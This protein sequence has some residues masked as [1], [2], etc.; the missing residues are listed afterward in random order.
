MSSKTKKEQRRKEKKLIEWNLQV[1]GPCQKAPLKVLLLCAH[2]SLPIP[3]G[4]S[5]HAF[6][7]GSYKCGHT[8]EGHVIMTSVDVFNWQDMEYQQT[9]NKNCLCNCWNVHVQTLSYFIIIIITIS[10][11]SGWRGHGGLA[12]KPNL[13]QPILLFLK[14]FNIISN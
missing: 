1:R 2:I 4:F 5:F 7:W 12:P 13:L 10:S 14:A 3:P 8:H 11:W 6:M 9:S